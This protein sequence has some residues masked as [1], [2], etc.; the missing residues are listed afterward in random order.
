MRRSTLAGILKRR[1]DFKHLNSFSSLL[2]FIS[3]SIPPHNAGINPRRAQAF[4]LHQRKHH[5][6][7]AVE[8]SG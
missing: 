6:K 8:A 3:L 1:I 5:E 4:N 7:K 2:N